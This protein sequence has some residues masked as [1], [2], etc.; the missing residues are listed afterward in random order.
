MKVLYFSKTS[1]IGPSSRYRI[2]QYLPHLRSCEVSIAV[3][4]LFGPAYFRLLAWQAVWLKI[5]AKFVYVSARFLK[6]GLDLLSI[7]PVDLIVIEGQLFPY[8]GPTAE[9]LLTKRYKVVVELDDAIYLTYR[10]S[11]KIPA[12]LRLSSGAIVGNRTLAEYAGAY[13]PNICVIPTVVDT[14]RFY[15]MNTRDWRMTSDDR[16][17]IIVWIGLDYNVSFLDL[18]VPAF[19]R[20][21]KNHRVIVRIISSRPYSLSGVTTEF[22]PW[23]FNTEV[24]DLQTSD[25]GVMPLPD[26]EWTRGKCGLKLLQYMAVGIPCVASPVGVNRD[27]ISDGHNGFLAATDEEWYARLIALCRD[28][29]MRSEIGRAGRNTVEADYSLKTWAPKLADAYRALAET[30]QSAKTGMAIADSSAL[31]RPSLTRRSR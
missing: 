19:Q 25:I 9:W 11:R 22:R 10:H 27:I 5:L 8:M 1:E 6:R 2:Y 16:P 26:M 31:P 20:L 12:L 15:P 18:L 4:P 21:Q 28:P 3:K 17:L 23:S 7:G 14:D 24:A 29:A 13:T 30:C